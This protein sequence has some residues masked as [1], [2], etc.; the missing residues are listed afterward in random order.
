MKL[1]ALVHV[2]GHS[3]DGI[4]SGAIKVSA[5]TN[6]IEAENEMYRQLDEIWGQMDQDVYDALYNDDFGYAYIRHES[7]NRQV[8]DHE[9]R[10][11]TL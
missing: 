7:F 3:L 2:S 5:Y 6:R 1:Y 10:I 9:W 11:T 8:Y 4:T